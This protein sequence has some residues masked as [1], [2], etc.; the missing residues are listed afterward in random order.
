MV[1]EGAHMVGSYLLYVDETGT[2]LRSDS[3]SKYP[4]FGIGGILVKRSDL[5]TIA[6]LRTN[7][8]NDWPKINNSP[9]HSYELRHRTGNFRWLEK[10]PPGEQARFFQQLSSMIGRVPA[11]ATACIVEKE[12]YF[13]RYQKRYGKHLWDMRKSAF[14]IIVERAAKFVDR[15]NESMEVCFERSSKVFDEMIIECYKSLIQTGSPFQRNYSSAYN[16]G[17]AAFFAR[18]LAGVRQKTKKSP[19][20]QI[21][22]LCLFALAQKKIDVNY[23]PYLTLLENNMVI[24]QH[25]PEADIYEIGVKYYCF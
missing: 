14:S 18:V 21:A 15:Q 6:T 23:Q 20:M 9:L 19:A 7:L 1:G 3:N 17:N 22:D 4:F 11:I 8:N 2:S 16:P 5:A 10:E 12:G 25:I 13:Y 24:D